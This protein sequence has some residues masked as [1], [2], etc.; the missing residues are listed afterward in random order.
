MATC[1]SHDSDQ[2][3]RLEYH[4]FSPMAALRV[5]KRRYCGKRGHDPGGI[6][7]DGKHRHLE[8]R[9]YRELRA[10]RRI[11]NRKFMNEIPPVTDLNEIMKTSEH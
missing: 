5:S 3:R 8:R 10:R 1:G 9:H 2:V 4:D 7:G 11:P 6:Q